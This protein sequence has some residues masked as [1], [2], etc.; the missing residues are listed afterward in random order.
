[1]QLTK[2]ITKPSVSASVIIIAYQYESLLRNA[3]FNHQALFPQESYAYF[4][5]KIITITLAMLK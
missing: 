5:A 2:R 4:N 3:I 1:L